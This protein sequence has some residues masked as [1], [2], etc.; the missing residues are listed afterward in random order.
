MVPGEQAR[1]PPSARRAGTDRQRSA[2]DA[3]RGEHWAK[4]GEVLDEVLGAGV[5][6]D[7]EVDIVRPSGAWRRA[8]MSV[9]ALSRANGEVGGAITCVL[10]ITDSARAREELEHRA[11]Y[12][13]LTHVHNR[14]SILAVAAGAARR[15][16]TASARVSS[17]STSTSSSPSTTRSAMRRATSCSCWSASA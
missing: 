10:D 7:V 4:F 8:L 5:D 15:A 17:T 1:R 14:S 2:A 9:R 16:R 12:D 13:T 11:T 3:H 6:R